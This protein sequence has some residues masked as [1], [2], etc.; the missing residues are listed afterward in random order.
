[1]ATSHAP[2][3]TAVDS[4]GPLTVLEA[5]QLAD[6]E[7][8][9][10]RGMRT[11]IEVGNA[12]GEI[13]ASRLYRQTHASFEEYCQVR[14]GM[15]GRRARQLIDATE[16]ADEIG[17]TV[18]L[19]TERAVR[20]LTVV[21]DDERAE[22]VAEVREK[23]EAGATPAEAVSEVMQARKSGTTVPVL[24]REPEPE[25]VPDLAAELERAHTEI[26][27]LQ[28]RLAILTADDSNAAIVALQT[29]NAALNGRLSQEIT[30]ANEARKQAE[31]QG[32]LLSKIRRALGVVNN[33]DILPAIDAAKR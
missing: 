26:A 6:C 14:W 32:K 29:K 16:V 12:L 21:P 24:G 28:E 19:L 2:T 7:A 22:A 4:I 23:I 9:I 13:K 27:D 5:A 3:P 8:V 15:T 18:P 10:E 20:P 31:W 30:T 33:A 17:T 11:F 25:D 1:M